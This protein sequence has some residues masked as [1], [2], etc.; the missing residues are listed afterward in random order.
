MPAAGGDLLDGCRLEA[1]SQEQLLR[2]LRQFGAKQSSPI[3]R[4]SSVSREASAANA[5]PPRGTGDWER[6][7]RIST[8]LSRAPKRDKSAGSCGNAAR[9]GGAGPEPNPYRCPFGAP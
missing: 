1:L 3:R 7:I 8:G 5:S 6:I 4:S 2:R 9:C